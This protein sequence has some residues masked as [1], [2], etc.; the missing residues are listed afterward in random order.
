MP[1]FNQKMLI[2]LAIVIVGVLIVFVTVN[3]E[4]TSK[5]QNSPQA[6]QTAIQ[7]NNNL[8]SSMNTAQ[9]SN[10]LLFVDFYADW[11]GYCKQLDEKTYSDGKVKQVMAQKYV[12][13]KVN[14]DQ[15]PDL[16]SKYSVY[17]LPTLIIMDSNGN[18]IKRLEGYQS[19]SQLLSML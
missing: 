1:T 16:A 15:N 19:P 17:G 13:V 18:V 10:K 6:N 5:T 8:N 3:L 12:A 2:I 9:N 7:W 14:V 4:K 11:C